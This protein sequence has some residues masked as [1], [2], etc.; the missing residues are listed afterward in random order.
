MLDYKGLSSI[1]NDVFPN[2][3]LGEHIN[4]LKVSKFNDEE[5]LFEI[6]DLLILKIRSRERVR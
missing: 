6:R 2:Y 1:W 3:S 5:M 4:E